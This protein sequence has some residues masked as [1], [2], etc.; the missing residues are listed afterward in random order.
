MDDGAIKIFSLNTSR[1]FGK[2]VAE[3]LG[4]ALSYHEERDFEDGEH[5]TRS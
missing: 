4:I 3:H 5:K 1:E 2:N